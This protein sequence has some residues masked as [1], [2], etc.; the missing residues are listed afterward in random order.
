MTRTGKSLRVSPGRGVAGLLAVALALAGASGTAYAGSAEVLA[1]K[2]E[3]V[4]ACD[5]TGFWDAVKLRGRNIKGRSQTAPLKRLD[6]GA[7]CHSFVGVWWNGTVT[8]TWVKDGSSRRGE[9]T[10]ETSADPDGP[11]W[12]ACFYEPRL[13]AR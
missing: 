12:Q 7:G 8:L 4:I 13:S 6:D 3:Q 9:S 11:N 10:C 1:A 5:E 2:G